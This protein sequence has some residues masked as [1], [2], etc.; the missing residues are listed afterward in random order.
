MKK[1][2]LVHYPCSLFVF[3]LQLLPMV[4]VRQKVEE[5]ITINAPRLKKVWGHYKKTMEM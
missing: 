1:L 2:Y 3:Y 5:E 4:P